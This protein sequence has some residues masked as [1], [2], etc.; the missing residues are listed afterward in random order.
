MLEVLTLE[1]LIKT[2]LLWTPRRLGTNDFGGLASRMSADL[3]A[4]YALRS[5]TST[6][7]FNPRSHLGVPRRSRG[8]TNYGR[9][10]CIP[11]SSL[12]ERPASFAE[13]VE[14]AAGAPISG[15]P[16]PDPGV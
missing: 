15:I 10:R 13:H 11:R 5:P 4:A 1:S 9:A 2:Q 12:H 6:L 3:Q 16:M 7:P 14:E 8:I